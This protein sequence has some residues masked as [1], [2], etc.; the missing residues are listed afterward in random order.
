M[1]FKAINLL[2]SSI[3]KE[4]NVN[5]TF[6]IMKDN[7]LFTNATVYGNPANVSNLIKAEMQKIKDSF[8]ALQTIPMEITLD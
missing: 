2:I 8:E 6:D 5:V 4:G 3:D 7:S 1:E